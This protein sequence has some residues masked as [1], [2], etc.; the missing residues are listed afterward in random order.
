M[1]QELPDD[2]KTEARARAN[3]RE[4]V[5]KI[6]D[7]HAFEARMPLYRLPGLL[8]A[9]ARP[10]HVC[11]GYDKRA[12]ALAISQKV[13]SG[14]AHDNRLSTCL[15]VGQIDEP[16]LKI[17][18][19]PFERQNLS[20]SRA[21]EHEEANGKDDFGRKNRPSVFFARQMLA[22]RFVNVRAPGQTLGFRQTQRF[23]A[24]VQLFN[25]QKSLARRL[26]KSLNTPR[27]IYATW[28][29]PR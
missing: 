23:P 2:W 20:Q 9:G 15:A 6:M 4:G 19:A 3:R 21:R 10:V 29:Y 8:Q 27:W 17:N 26:T 28:N 1:T 18:M 7:A 14:C 25:S 5:T 13:E 12:A 11:S 16:T 24:T 22:L